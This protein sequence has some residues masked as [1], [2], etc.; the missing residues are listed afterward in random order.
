[1]NVREGHTARKSNMGSNNSK[2][3]AAKLLLGE[4]IDWLLDTTETHFAD[5]LQ[6]R[7]LQ[8]EAD[9]EG[10][11]VLIWNTK[12]REGYGGM[13]FV[14]RPR[15]FVTKL[16]EEVEKKFDE[17]TVKCHSSNEGVVK[18]VSLRD[19]V[20]AEYREQTVRAAVK[21][22]V[23]GALGQLLLTMGRALEHQYKDSLTLAVAV[24]EH[25]C[26]MN[27]EGQT[28]EEDGDRVTV[29]EIERR[30]KA[31]AEDRVNDVAKQKRDY[32]AAL[33]SNIPTLRV[34][35]G[36][37]G[38]PLG[39][40]K[41]AEDR[42]RE[43]LEFEQRIESAVRKLLSVSGGIPTKTE[44][45]KELN[46]GW[47]NSPGGNNTRLPT[48]NSKLERLGVDYDAIVKKVELKVKSALKKTFLP[49]S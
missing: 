28:Y 15:A 6:E 41:S 14:Y 37:P 34:P 39:T 8:L 4:V 10:W 19:N 1:L 26:V 47:S 35:T 42:Q 2:E 20:A 27:F 23:F 38:R 7:G 30:V 44:V 32:L 22:S 49:S 11:A 16:Y 48:F 36:K 17:L 29:L 9:A 18:Q 21:V 33:L 40:G 13:S 46:M 3:S 31:L 12:D 25:T 5:A 43:K 45:A 24:L